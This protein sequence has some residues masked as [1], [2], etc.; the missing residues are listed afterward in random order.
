MVYNISQLPLRSRRPISQSRLRP[1]GW[2]PSQRRIG[3]RGHRGSWA[4]SSGAL[5]GQSPLQSS[6]AAWG[7]IHPASFAESLQRGE[8]TA[9][10][11]HTETTAG[12]R[13]ARTKQL[14]HLICLSSL[15]TSSSQPENRL[16][17][18][19]RN[20][21]GLEEQRHPGQPSA[22][23]CILP[24]TRAGIKW[25]REKKKTCTSNSLFLSQGKP[26]YAA[27]VADQLAS[28]NPGCMTW[29]SP[30]QFC[31]TESICKAHFLNDTQF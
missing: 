26:K 7:A 21:Y 16:W 31:N 15:P 29:S 10:V 1:R 19:H 30:S 6:P 4:G 8:R 17:R 28:L 20:V 12:V 9:K 11:K 25:L 24:L 27:F 2:T 22:K 5:S 3:C 13:V 14:A 18:A 23:S